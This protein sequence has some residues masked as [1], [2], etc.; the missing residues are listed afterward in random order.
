VDG[1]DQVAWSA[2][3]EVDEERY[4]LTPSAGARGAWIAMPAVVFVAVL[5]LRSAVRGRPR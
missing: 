5:L 2:E 1:D 4:A 3:I